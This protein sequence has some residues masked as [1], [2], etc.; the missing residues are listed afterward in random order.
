MMQEKE[1]RFYSKKQEKKFLMKVEE[2][3]RFKIEKDRFKYTS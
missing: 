3:D 1:K 2:I